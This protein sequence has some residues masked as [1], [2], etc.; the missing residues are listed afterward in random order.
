VN[1]EAVHEKAVTLGEDCTGIMAI[2]PFGYSFAVWTG[3]YTGTMNPQKG[4]QP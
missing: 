2:F 4:Q 3:D 1:G